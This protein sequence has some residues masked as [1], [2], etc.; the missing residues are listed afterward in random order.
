MQQ[1][2]RSQDWYTIGITQVIFVY[3]IS[4]ETVQ[5]TIGRFTMHHQTRWVRLLGLACV[6]LYLISFYLI[7]VTPVANRVYKPTQELFGHILDEL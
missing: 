7:A 5:A 6:G 1:L 3:Q 2:P 4:E